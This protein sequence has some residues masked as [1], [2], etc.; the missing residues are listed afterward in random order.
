MAFFD[1]DPLL[2]TMLDAAPGISD[3]NISVGRPPQVEVDGQLRGVAFAGIDK[4]SPYHTEQVVMRLLAGKRD[5]ADKLVKTG[6]TDLSYSLAGRTRFRVN[7]FSQRGTYCI[8][9]RVIPNKIPTVDELGIPPQ[10]N[11]ITKERNG[12]VLVTGPTGSGKST[13]LAAIINKF[14][15][16]KAMHIITIED[17][18]EYMHPHHKATIN[19]REVGTDTRD[20]SLALRAALRQAPKVILVGEMRDVETI[21][22]ALEA[23]ETGHLVLSTLHTIDASKT[24]DRIVGVFPKNEERQIRTRFSQSFR[25]V[26]SQRLVPKKTG[27]RLAVCEILRSTARTREYVQEGERE[28]KSLIDAMNDSVLDG[29]QSFD[30]ELERLINAGIVDRE[31]GLSYSTNRT[32]LQLRLE[33]NADASQ[34]ESVKAAGASKPAPAKKAAPPQPKNEMDDLIER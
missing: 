6:S 32:N 19:Q 25:W 29:M 4:L 24:I 8:V 30:Y 28:G 12:I 15:L 14:N 16:E 11:E 26:V 1:V 22:I 31:V 5:A 10:L 17:P 34:L 2:E 20:F 9:L 23:S 27:G 7:I 33:T 13:T 18:V 3:L 21:S